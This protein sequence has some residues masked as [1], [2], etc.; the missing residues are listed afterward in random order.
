MISLI[1]KANG[2]SFVVT[3]SLMWQAYV[4]QLESSRLKL[5]Q[6]EQEVQQARPQVF[7]LGR[8]VSLIFAIFSSGIIFLIGLIKNLLFNCRVVQP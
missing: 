5:T 3:T 8:S 7:F 4:Q 6:L 2:R 1:F